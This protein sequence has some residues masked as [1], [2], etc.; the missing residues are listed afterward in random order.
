MVGEEGVLGEESVG[1]G[2]GSGICLL[3][4]EKGGSTNVEA[5]EAHELEE[6]E[7]YE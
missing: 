5:P 4:E 1:H 2:H 7:C 3:F 6:Y